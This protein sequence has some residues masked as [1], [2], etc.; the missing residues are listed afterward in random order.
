ME[1]LFIA[2]DLLDE[3]RGFSL[4]FSRD[5]LLRIWTNQVSDAADGVN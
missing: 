4:D 1:S 2:A 5:I 3:A